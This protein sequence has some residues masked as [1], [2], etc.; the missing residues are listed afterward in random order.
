MTRCRITRTKKSRKLSRDLGQCLSDLSSSYHLKG[1]SRLFLQLLSSNIC[2]MYIYIYIYTYI[3]IYR[4]SKFLRKMIRD[5]CHAGDGTQPSFQDL[6]HLRL[7]RQLQFA[8][9]HAKHPLRSYL[10][11]RP[12]VQLAQRVAFKWMYSMAIS[13]S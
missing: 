9:A 13:G 5:A 12:V 7:Q 1:Q 4:A 11:W 10:C 8:H 2:I 3:Y 6:I